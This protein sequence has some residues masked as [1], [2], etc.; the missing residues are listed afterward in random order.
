MSRRLDCSFSYTRHFT[1]EAL[2]AT[3]RELPPTDKYPWTEWCDRGVWLAKRG[4]DFGVDVE[5]LRDM[6]RVRAFRKSLAVRTRGYSDAVVFQFEPKEYSARRR[7]ARQVYQAKKAAD[8]RVHLAKNLMSHYGITLEEWDRL[9]LGSSGRCTICLRPF[10]N[11]TH[12]PHVDHCHK[13]GMVRELLC[14]R[15]NQGLGFFEDAEFRRG[16]TAYVLRHRTRGI[17]E[18]AD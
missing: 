11:S 2:V 15:C 5:T 6:L 7:R 14:R 10:K 17:V 3:G 13:T 18:I 9:L 16:V 12:E 8:P 4:E 1:S